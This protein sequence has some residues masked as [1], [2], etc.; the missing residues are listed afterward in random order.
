MGGYGAPHS[1]PGEQLAHLLPE[2]WRALHRATGAPGTLPASEAQVQILRK[3]CIFGR[4]SPAQLA[5]ELKLARPTVSNL[6]GQ[7]VADGM[8]RREPS[9][10]DRRSVLLEATERGLE[11]L[12]AFRRHRAEVLDEALDEMPAL[13]RNQILTALPSLGS[14][15][16]RLEER[17][18][19][20][21]DGRRRA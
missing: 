19:T 9:V 21:P 6:V 2:V 17:V 7:L 12:R 5:V 16:E 15:L 20:E 4:I 11:A 18:D 1:S 10:A 3:L 13:A 14:L 8:V